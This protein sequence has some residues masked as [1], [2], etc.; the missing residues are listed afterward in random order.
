MRR[1]APSAV[2]T[3][4]A[5]PKFPR[6]T[7]AKCIEPSCSRRPFVEVLAGVRGPRRRSTTPFGNCGDERPQLRRRRPPTDPA[8]V[9]ST[10]RSIP[11]RGFGSRSSTPIETDGEVESDFR[12][13]LRCRS[14][15]RSE[16]SG[17]GRQFQERRAQ[18]RWIGAAGQA[19]LVPEGS[20]KPNDER[21]FR[22]TMRL[23][24]RVPRSNGIS[25]GPRLRDRRWRLTEP[26]PAQE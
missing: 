4:P 12:L 2:R 1:T 16:E 17:V 23:D 15:R 24:D 22:S 13:R 8:P 14:F 18:G 20:L 9:R 19:V 26:I 6:E 10:H 5:P 21:V 7:S 3:Q 25:G 11:L